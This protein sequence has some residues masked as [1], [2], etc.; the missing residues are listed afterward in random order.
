MASIPLPFPT[1]R[2]RIVR[3]VNDERDLTPDQRMADLC[4]MLNL[5]ASLNPTEDV[6]GSTVPIWQNNK[7]EWQRSQRELFQRYRAGRERRN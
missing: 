6:F 1:N 7:A 3:Q 4:D 2:Q 5:A